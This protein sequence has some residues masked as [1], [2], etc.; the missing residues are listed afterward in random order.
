[1]RVDFNGYAVLRA[2]LQNL[3]DVHVVS[4]TPLQ[5]ASGHMSDDC[6]VRVPDCFEDALRLLLCSLKRL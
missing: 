6:G 4:R 5:L 3:V 1:M 2:G